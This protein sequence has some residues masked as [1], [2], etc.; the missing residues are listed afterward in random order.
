MSY[1]MIL[2]VK[3]RTGDTFEGT[4]WYPAPGNG[5]I[6]VTGRIDAKGMVTFTDEKVIYGTRMQERHVGVVAGSTYE[7]SLEG[8]TLKGTGDYRDGKDTMTFALKLAK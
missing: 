2:F 8:T 4:T 7:A 6:K 5:L 3:Q 1:P